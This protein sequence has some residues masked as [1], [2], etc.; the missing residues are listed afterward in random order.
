MDS[1]G[2]LESL[3]EAPFSSE[4]VLQA[5]ITEHPDCSRVSK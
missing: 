1:K 3:D 4:E 5:L 2:D